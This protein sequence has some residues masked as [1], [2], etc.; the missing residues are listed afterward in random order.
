MQ[1]LWPKNDN[2]LNWDPEN[3]DK[4]WELCSSFDQY[5]QMDVS[6]SEPESVKGFTQDRVKPRRIF[7]F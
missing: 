1:T 6:A 5:P 3:M 4:Y 7:R 2:I